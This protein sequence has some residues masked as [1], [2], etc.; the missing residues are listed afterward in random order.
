LFF[1][2]ARYLEF[3]AEELSQKSGTPYTNLIVVSDPVLVGEMVFADVVA[4]GDDGLTVR[5]V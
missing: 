1:F 3:L 5:I 2:D 4:I